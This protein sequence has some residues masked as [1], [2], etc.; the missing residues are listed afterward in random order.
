V[1][2][3]GGMLAADLLQRG[4]IDEYRVILNLVFIGSGTPL[5]RG[6]TMGLN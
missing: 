3:G 2:L 5:F 6:I 1:I 4:M